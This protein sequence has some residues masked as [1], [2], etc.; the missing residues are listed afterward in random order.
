[1]EKEN[2]DLQGQ[3]GQDHLDAEEKMKEEVSEKIAE[4]AAELQDEIDAADSTAEDVDIDVDEA[5]TDVDEMA[6]EY[7]EGLQLS[8]EEEGLPEVEPIPE[9][10]KVTMGVG[11]FVASLIGCVALGLLIM[12]VCFKAPG[13]M[14]KIPEGST[15]AKVNGDSITDKDLEYYIYTAATEYYTE[16]TTDTSGSNMDSYDWDQTTSDGQKVSDIIKEDALNMAIDNILT[17]Q[18]SMEKGVEWSEQEENSISTSVDGFVEQYGED[19]FALRTRAM[20]IS[21]PKQY[22]RMYIQMMQYANASDDIENDISK[23]LPDDVNV[24]NDYIRDD[25]ASVKHILI[26]TTDDTDSSQEAGAETAVDASAAKLQTAQQVLER[27]RNGEDFDS[28][29]DEFNEDTGEGD[30]GYTFTAGEMVEEF[31]TAAFA[32]KMN[33]ISDV[34]TSSYGYHIIKRIPGIYE[35]QN[36]WKSEAKISQNDNKLAEISVSDIM[37]S[38][39]EAQQELQAQQSS[40]SSSSN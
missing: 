2:K 9:P 10:K 24:L 34:V 6:E 17:I 35:L 7:V 37:N 18:K 14:E 40:S 15:V 22:K 31:E 1:M 11:S 29:M 26:Q 21:S 3:S 38:A 4:A 20:G 27:A 19:G 39:L 23:Y 5:Q 12:F 36:M 28:L 13:W 32:L 30:T 33:E 8:T 25:R 16:N